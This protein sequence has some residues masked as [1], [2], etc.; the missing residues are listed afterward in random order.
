MKAVAMAG[1]EGTRLWPMTAT[2]P[3]PLLPVV[4]APIMEH[5]LRLLRRHGIVEI[6]VTMV[7]L[8]AR[9]LVVRAAVA[10]ADSA[11]RIDTTDGVR[12][13]VDDTSWVL[14]IPD[15]SEAL[16]HVWVEGSDPATST[17][18]INARSAVTKEAGR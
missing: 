16:A 4:N 3:K 2:L 5:V 14:V 10:E 11:Y 9:T 15:E 13:P 1:G 7:A 18:L 17:T 6:V 12:G 8:V